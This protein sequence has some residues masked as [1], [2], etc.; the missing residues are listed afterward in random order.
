MNVYVMVSLQDECQVDD[1]DSVLGVY[2]DT[3]LALNEAQEHF[4]D[5]QDLRV[6][7]GRIVGDY[8]DGEEEELAQLV[9]H[10]V[11]TS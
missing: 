4:S 3:D 2:T 8:I 5:Y 7:R 11:V 1:S 10:Q 9:L 6:E